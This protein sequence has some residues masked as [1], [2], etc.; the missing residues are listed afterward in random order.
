[1]NSITTHSL[2]SL[3][4]TMP[5]SQ[6]VALVALWK[7]KRKKGKKINLLESGSLFQICHLGH[8]YLFRV[9]CVQDVLHLL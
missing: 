3:P 9:S 2:V 5:A 8:L 1:M 7:E 4:R 6:V